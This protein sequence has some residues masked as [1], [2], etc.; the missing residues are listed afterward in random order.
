MADDEFTLYDLKVEWVTGDRP[1]WCGAQEGDHFTLRGE[2]IHMPS[3]TKWSLYTL[4][5]LLPLLPA[6]QRP[7]DDNDW[8]STD[9][10]VACPDPN[11]GSR[12][13]I[14]RIGSTT[15]RHSETTAVQLT[16]P[17]GDND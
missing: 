5:S 2:H 6:K 14:S 4:A 15:F 8:M 10:E 16:K 11:C 12:F 3:G 17:G 1:C 9:A 7:T 13:R